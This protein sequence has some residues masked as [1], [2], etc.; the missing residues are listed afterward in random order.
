MS[1][2]TAELSGIISKFGADY[3][4]TTPMKLKLI[5]AYLGYCFFT[6]VIQVCTFIKTENTIVFN[7][8]TLYHIFAVRVLLFGWN[9]PI[10]RLFGWIHFQREWPTEPSPSDSDWAERWGIFNAGLHHLIGVRG[11]QALAAELQKADSTLLHFT[12]AFSANASLRRRILQVQG[13]P[14]SGKSRVLLLFLL[15]IKLVRPQFKVLWLAKQNPTLDQSAQ[16]LLMQLDADGR[17]ASG[18]GRFPA[19]RGECFQAKENISFYKTPDL[20]GQLGVTMLTFGRL[21]QDMDTAFFPRC[22]WTRWP[23]F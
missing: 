17:L 10:Q 19:H 13:P 8:S 3:Q 6:G 9:F 2:K 11:G 23:W 21:E 16:D 7:I 18:V 20:L 12:L 1:A 22:L 14:G 4:K 15:L 5:D